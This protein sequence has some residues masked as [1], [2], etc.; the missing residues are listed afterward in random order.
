MINTRKKLKLPGHLKIV[1]MESVRVNTDDQTIIDAIS[2]LIHSAQ[3]ENKGMSRDLQSSIEEA[4]EVIDALTE[5]NAMD[6][7]DDGA[8][9]MEYVAQHR[10]TWQQMGIRHG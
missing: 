3:A 6:E 1:K 7:D 5:K 8:Q 4:Q 10:L 9:Y 2:N